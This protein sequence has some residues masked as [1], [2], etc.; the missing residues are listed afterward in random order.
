MPLFENF[1]YTNF[2]E[3]NLDWILQELKKLVDEWDSFG[4]T[5]S[6]SAHVSSSPEVN[7][8]GDLKDGLAF[9]FGL[10]QGPRGLT[11]PEG[12]EGPE[13]PQGA[14]LE[15]LDEYA[16]LADLQTAHPT[17]SAGDAYL[18]GTGGSFTLYI[19]STD[20]TAWVD[21]G[22]LS[23]PS[24]YTSLP[25]MDG[26]ASSGSSLNYSRGDHVHPSDSSKMNLDLLAS[27]GEL[28]VF[29]ASGQ[30]EGAGIASS[31]VQLIVGSAVNGNIASFDASGQVEDSGIAT[32][33]IA[34]QTDLAGYQ[35]LVP[36][37]VVSDI[38]V[39]DGDGQVIDGA[40]SIS[41]IATQTDL[42]SYLTITG[43]EQLKCIEVVSSSFST[44]PQTINDAL[45]TAD[46]VVV[47]SIL[48]HPEAQKTEWTVTTN[49]GSLT[50]SG[51]ISGSTSITLYLIKKRS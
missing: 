2:H 38:A 9:D 21:G 47:N 19:W 6:A 10:V 11:G 5:V 36:T 41:D 12:P 15:I 13:G 4:G 35:E 31:D 48:S 8:S 24:P 42:A 30:V 27:A 7:V 18:V 37:A 26:V 17:G 20:Q 43:S 40:V 28:A 29:D 1:P 23:S 50:I 39:F 34:T 25:A 3:M 44:L 16:T 46:H 14:G 45:I 32:T 51:T 22:A 33:E 49:S